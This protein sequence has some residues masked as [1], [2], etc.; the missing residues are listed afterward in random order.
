MFIIVFVLVN[1]ISLWWRRAES[2]VEVRCVIARETTLDA[3][4][5]VLNASGYVTARRM[6]TVS[7][8][9][10]G[11]VMEVLIEEGMEVEQGQVLA[12][13]DATNVLAS[14]ELA[15]ASLKAT[16]AALDETV[17]RIRQ[18]E[19]DRDRLATLVDQEVT[20]LAELDRAQAELD[21]AKA[22]LELQRQ[23]VTVARQ[24]IAVVEQQVKDTEIRAP[25][26]G[27][28]VAK[29]AQP[30]EMI[31]PMSAGGFTRTG[32][33]AVVDMTSLEIE[34]DVNESYINRVEPGQAVQAMLD[35]YPEWQI[36][37]HV[38]AIIPTADRQRATVRVRIG[39]DELDPRIL[40]DMGVKVAFQEV[41]E[42]HQARI[43][44]V[45]PRKALVREA[46][47]DYVYVVRDKRANRQ[48]V[49]VATQGGGETILLSG[50]QAG[51][52]VVAEATAPL[53]DG[54]RVKELH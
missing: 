14:K 20:S 44:I 9:I 54:D 15:Y 18:A 12:R 19:L 52:K 17:V 29:N 2:L 3:Q 24:Q 49:S 53:S 11:K 16:E 42:E 38:I 46:E 21:S 1:V 36:A 34:V 26:A 10:T 28:I 37:A 13:L 23:E 41:S 30:G 35:A 40:P 43:G 25:F 45:V 48:A 7:S 4:R 8:K 32:I 6:A 22:R 50:V 27:V 31:S 51:D 33:G 47:H 39:F 5:T